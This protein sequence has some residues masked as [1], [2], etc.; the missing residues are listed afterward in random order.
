MYLFTQLI[1]IIL[2][3]VPSMYFINIYYIIIFTYYIIYIYNI[4]YKNIYIL[5]ITYFIIILWHI[6]S[7][8]YILHMR[9]MSLIVLFSFFYIIMPICQYFLNTVI[10]DGIIEAIQGILL[11]TMS[12]I[13]I[14]YL[15]QLEILIYFIRTPIKLKLIRSFAITAA[16]DGIY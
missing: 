2:S 7:Y 3:S 16:H 6:L 4:Y 1:A 13:S 14:S 11:V 8:K 10:T 12:S 5:Y 15:K 9:F